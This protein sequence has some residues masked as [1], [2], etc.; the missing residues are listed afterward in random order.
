MTLSSRVP[1]KWDFTNT[2]HCLAAYRVK[3]F[4]V[5]LEDL[6]LFREK[7]RKAT[8]L[9]SGMQGTLPSVV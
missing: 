4:F 6:Y 9:L 7:K 2:D 1:G 5:H 8:L 3:Y